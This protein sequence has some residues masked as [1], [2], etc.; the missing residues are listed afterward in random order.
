LARASATEQGFTNVE[1]QVGNADDIRIPYVEFDLIFSHALFEHLP[2][3]LQVLQHLRPLLRSEGRVALRSPD[4]GGWVLYPEKSDCMAA[5]ATYGEL[6]HANGGDIHAGRKL[7]SWLTATGFREV[8]VSASYEIYPSAGMIAD[9]LAAQLDFV[10]LETHATA[11][12]NWSQ[13]PGALFA[14]AWFEAIGL[15]T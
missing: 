12:R 6:Q 13:E 8:K 9:Y 11:L 10:G 7:G 2:D 4:W 15:K 3:P 14:Q 5:I 1:F